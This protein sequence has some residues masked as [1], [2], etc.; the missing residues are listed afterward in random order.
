M[1]AVICKSDD[2]LDISHFPSADKLKNH[3]TDYEKDI[4]KL[5][6]RQK[7]HFING[8]K[9]FIAKDESIAS[10]MAYVVG[11]LF[12]ADDFGDKIGESSKKMLY[13]TI[14]DLA[15]DIMTSIDKDISFSIMSQKTVDWIEKTGPYLGEIM[16]LTSHEAVEKAIRTG[17]ENGE[18]ID[19]IVDRIKVL[20]EFDRKRA[21]TTAIT[22]VLAASSAAS[23]EAFSQ[24]PSVEG[25]TWLH[26]GGKGITPRPAHVAYSNT[27]VPVE[28]PFQVG[29]EFGMYPRS[30]E[31][32]A[33]NRV[34]CHCVMVPS[35]NQ[36]IL[37]LSKE[38]K[39][40]IREER[41]TLL[42]GYAV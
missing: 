41:V 19:K 11:N 2:K 24:S 42:G 27:T 5:Q 8:I 29:G 26:S 9:E 34:R 39:E 7:R 32:S 6:R 10:I 36:D 37:K 4:A 28:E 20:P 23:Q 18:G 16:K 22:E 15:S 12:A 21:E 38:E 17:I 1:H 31:F 13:K 30:M 33:R 35:V 3:I 25:K 40:K 14:P